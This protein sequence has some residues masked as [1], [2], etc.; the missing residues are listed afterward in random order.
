[1]FSTDPRDPA[2]QLIQVL[3]L[4]HTETDATRADALRRRAAALDE[5]V[6]QQ[7]R[8]YARELAARAQK[9]EGE[10]ERK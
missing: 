6:R 4:L 2:I 10:K 3:S 5:E 9:T 7:V 1:L 8:Q